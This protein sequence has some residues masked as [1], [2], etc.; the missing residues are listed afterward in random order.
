MVKKIGIKNKELDL[1][2]DLS[3]TIAAAVAAHAALDTGVHGAG[4][5]TL[6]TLAD[7]TLPDFVHTSICLSAYSGSVGTWALGLTAGVAVNINNHGS[8][9]NG[10]YLEWEVWL[11]AG[12]YTA[13]VHGST[14][15]NRGITDFLI[16]GV[17]EG[18]K[19]W[20]SA[21]AGYT[22][23]TFTFTVAATGAQTIRMILDGKNGSSS[24]YEAT[25]FTFH[26]GRTS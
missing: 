18:S 1:S 23:Y 22:D 3:G 25:I 9:N 4:A 26:I 20:Y 24:D 8:N 21:G 11:P 12:N 5:S 19:D 7:I 10:D 17:E 6:A 16:E 13:Q 14:N 15:T 2:G